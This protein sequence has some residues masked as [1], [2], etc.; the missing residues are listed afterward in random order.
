MNF[1]FAWRYFKSKKTTNAINIIAWV[2]VIAIAVVTAAI[3]IVLSVF[4]GFEGLVKGLYADFYADIKISATEAKTLHL[5]QD[6]LAQIKQVKGVLNYSCIAEEKAVVLNDNYQ[7]IVVLK[8]VDKNYTTV[9]NIKNYISRGKFETGNTA[10]PQIILGAGVENA[11]N[12]DV[13]HAISPL[14]LYLPNKK[15]T[16]SITSLES[17]NSATIMP[18]GSFLV[19]QEFDNKYAFSN[20]DFI[21]YMLDMSAD[22][23]TAVEVKINVLAKPNDVKDELVK[24]L[25]NNFKVETRYEQNRSLYKIMQVEKWFIY[26]LLSL[27][28]LVAAFNIVGALTMLVLDKKKDIHILK[29]MGAN[30][31][32]IQKIF[33]SEGVLLAS[34][35]GLIGIVLA[36][37]ICVIQ[38]KFHLI[39]LQ[40]GTFIIDYYPVQ[41]QAID[42]LLTVIT[43]AIIALMASWIPSRKAATAVETL[44]S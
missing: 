12:A 22:E 13:E 19:Q 9:S 40:G 38:Q 35:G 43:I 31:Y 23:Y 8:G 39:K 16:A 33:L 27:I 34:I 24:L 2:S 32:V 37:I 18:I 14:L 44:K 20:L 4:N 28:M 41:M 15:S 25:G 42:F 30:N 10:H 5:S 6:K 7:S 1:T 17:F 29:A 11:V 21:K 3:I 36:T 26:A